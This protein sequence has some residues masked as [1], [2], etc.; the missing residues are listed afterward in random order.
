MKKK[1]DILI[2]ED[3]EENRRAAQEYF[4]MR[5]DVC[6]D[7]APNYDEGVRKLQ[8]GLYGLGIF[9]LELPR[10]EED[11][12]EKLGF[13]LAREA[14]K[15]AMPWAVITA[16]ID[17]HQC[18]AAFVSYS[19]EGIKDPNEKLGEIT[20]IPKTDLRSWQNVYETLVGCISNISETASA[21]ERY[22][23]FVGKS[24]QL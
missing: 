17:H 24:Y 6:V 15:Y 22:K 19:W 20:E 2:V 8:T 18:K 23:R 1:L 7:F 11:E 4:D 13:E 14:T 3:R 16:G 21:R 9:D 12:P 10:S 5:S